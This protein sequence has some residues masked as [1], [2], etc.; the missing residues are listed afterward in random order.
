MAQNTGP[1]AKS[2]R[3]G[4]RHEKSPEFECEKFI[5]GVGYVSKVSLGN[6]RHIE[7]G[8]QDGQAQ[9]LK[10]GEHPLQTLGGVV[11]R[12]FFVHFSVSR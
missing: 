10:S 2:E 5:N 1:G 11:G 12:E 3:Q 4:R 6:E 7:R 9:N 8:E